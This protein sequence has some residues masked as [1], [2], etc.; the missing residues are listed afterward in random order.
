[1]AGPDVDDVR[2]RWRDGDGAD[3]SRRLI[4]EERYPVGTVVRRA[5][6]AAIVEAGVEDVGMTRVSGERARAPRTRRPDVAPAPVLEGQ[7][8]G[9]RCGRMNVEEDGESDEDE[10]VAHAR[11][12]NSA[13]TPAVFLR[14]RLARFGAPPFDPGGGR[15]Q[16]QQRAPLYVHLLRVDE[17]D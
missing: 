1:G 6:D 11:Y 13:S 10:T 12:P 8:L 7:I 4:V 9:H 17:V 3:R 16:D 5:P 14:S 2:V 15:E